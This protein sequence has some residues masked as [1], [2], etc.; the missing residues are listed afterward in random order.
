MPGQWVLDIELN[1]G[2]HVTLPPVERV[3]ELYAQIEDLRER[4]TRDHG[5][6]LGA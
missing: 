6:R 5:A 3:D 2:D 1:F 4:S